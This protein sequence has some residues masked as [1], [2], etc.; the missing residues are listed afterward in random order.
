MRAIQILLPNIDNSWLWDWVERRVVSTSRWWRYLIFKLK[1]IVPIVI[2][3]YK[4][5]NEI[6]LVVERDWRDWEKYY[7]EEK[8]P[9][10]C[11]LLYTG[12]YDTP[13]KS[14]QLW[15]RE[16]TYNYF[17]TEILLIGGIALLLWYLFQLRYPF[18]DFWKLGPV[19]VEGM[20]SFILSSAKSFSLQKSVVGWY[21]FS[22]LSE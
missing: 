17:D 11:V 15:W 13:V 4:E 9:Q 18:G 5:S 21:L 10:M 16:E 8:S 6:I 14:Y 22:F 7:L 2:T 1:R 20:S 19:I 12:T 3:I